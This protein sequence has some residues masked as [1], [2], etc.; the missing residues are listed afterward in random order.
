LRYA[1]FHLGRLD[2]G[3]PRSAAVTTARQPAVRGFRYLQGWGQIGLPGAT[4]LLSDG[5]MA[6]A[7]AV[8][9][10]LPEA[11][12]GIVALTN[13]TRGAVYEAAFAIL[14]AL[15]P[16]SGERLGARIEEI[17]RDLAKPGVAPSGHYEGWIGQGDARTAV[18]L[19]VPAEGPPTL[20]FGDDGPSHLLQSISWEHGAWTAAVHGSLAFGA[21][22]E[23]THRLQLT[24]WWRDGKLQGVAE[25]QLSADRPGFSAPHF[26]ELRAE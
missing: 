4:V 20:T 24:L 12:L 7:A 5:Q 25:E 10:L 21:G 13:R 14:S 18:Q 16:G 22:K 26:V 15:L 17:E 2:S 8:V 6:G 9:L 19:D 3:V 11:D 1:L 23:R